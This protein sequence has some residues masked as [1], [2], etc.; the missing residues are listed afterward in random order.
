M[1][2]WLLQHVYYNHSSTR[3]SQPPANTAT[4]GLLSRTLVDS[5]QMG[6]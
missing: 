3:G 2:Q 4:V 5:E 6:P 1:M